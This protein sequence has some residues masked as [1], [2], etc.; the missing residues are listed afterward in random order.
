MN[1]PNKKIQ[2]V[3]FHPAIFFLKSNI[4]KLLGWNVFMVLFLSSQFLAYQIYQV[5]LDNETKLVQNEALNIKDKLESGLN[6]SISVTNIIAYL[7]EKDLIENNFEQVSKDLLAQ[8]QFVDAIQLVVGRK[9]IKTYPAEGN[10]VAIG[11]D[12]FTID[13]HSVQAKKSIERRQLYFDGPFNLMQGG[14]GIVGRNP[15]FKNG[16]FYGFAAVIIK[17]ETFLSILHLDKSGENEDFIYQLSKVNDKGETIDGFLLDNVEEFEGAIVSKY[18]ANIG[19]WAF[20]VK[21]KNSKI[22]FKVVP[23]ALLGCLLSVA[24]GLLIWNI[25]RQPQKLA[26]MVAQ[27]TSELN[28]SKEQY[29]LLFEN[30]PS[31]VLV[32]D[33]NTAR[34]QDFNQAAVQ[35]YGYSREELKGKSIHDFEVNQDSLKMEAG[36]QEI[37]DQSI[38]WLHF[39]KTGEKMYL[40]CSLQN[41]EYQGKKCILATLNDIT[42]I[43]L[44]KKELKES[45]ERFLLASK[46]TSDA[47]W[48]YNFENEQLHWGEG[49]QSLFGYNISEFKP[50][51]MNHFELIHPEDSRY[52]QDSFVSAIQEINQVNWVSKYR[53]KKSNGEYTLV[54]N[55]GIIVRDA[56]GK[57]VKVVG[58]M[59]D[60]SQINQFE[61]SL[62]KLNTQ[63][64]SSNKDLEEFAYVVS[65]DLQEPIRMISSFLTLLEK[66]YENILDEKG[67]NYIDFAVNG[68]KK[69]KAMIQ[70]LLQY[71]R[72]GRIVETPINVDIR[73]I[74]DEVKAT[75]QNTILETNATIKTGSLPVIVSNKTLI[76][77]LFQNL[78]GNALK[79]KKE[80]IDIIISITATQ[81][82]THWQFA[83]S[84]NGIG[85][86]ADYF[87]KIF[88]I[89]QRVDHAGKFTGNGIGL[90]ICKKIAQFLGGNIWVESEENVGSTFF[91]TIK[92]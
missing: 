36:Q 91:F 83:V 2:F 74:I 79:Y 40:E 29:R 20:Y 51:T 33:I 49:F 88:T 37:E 54:V 15:V 87:E 89:F 62:R 72:V 23:I 1:T 28:A 81:S 84:D 47:I 12:I 75:F 42:A 85:I 50:T 22:L 38:I 25:N 78:I 65:H 32:W 46:A 59:K 14:Y 27:R 21:Y 86:N 30:N 77:Q 60:I 10:E 92:K 4:P 34:L 18:I 68:S 41:I 63:L 67:R 13:Q 39:N 80:N 48:E 52:V 61:V 19:N 43:S 66:R 31:P 8:N 64:L 70:D 58:A 44:S 56:E 17:M 11:Y 76:T 55:L 53:F 3:N 69:M 9:I 5:E 73:E 71:S 90:T 57:P 45:N 7:M 26:Q 16:E 24:M 6:N 35:K 82:P